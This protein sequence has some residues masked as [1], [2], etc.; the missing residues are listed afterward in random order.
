MWRSTQFLAER[1]AGML[2]STADSLSQLSLA[3]KCPI[4]T[5]PNEV[6]AKIFRIFISTSNEL[7]TKR[8]MLVCR[9]W[10]QVAGA[11][12]ELYGKIDLDKS[13]WSESRIL[14]QLKRSGATPLEV[15][16]PQLRSKTVI[17]PLLACADRLIALKVSGQPSNVLEL[18]RRMGNLR[19]PKLHELLLRSDG[20]DSRMG[21]RVAGGTWRQ[22]PPALLESGLPSLRKLTVLGI[23]GSFKSLAGLTSLSLAG[24]HASNPAAPLIALHDLL[25]MLAA[26]PGLE[27]LHIA[28]AT[29]LP[30]QDCD[31]ACVSLLHLAHLELC[32]RHLQF[33]LLLE[34]LLIPNTTI[35]DL[36]AIDANSAEE[37]RDAFTPLTTHLKKSGAPSAKML[38]LRIGGDDDFTITTHAKVRPRVMTTP[39]PWVDE[40][41]I[42]VSIAMDPSSVP[43]NEKFSVVKTLLEDVLWPQIASITHLDLRMAEFPQGMYFRLLLNMFLFNASPER[44]PLTLAMISDELCLEALLT[45]L[46]AE[47]GSRQMGQPFRHVPDIAR[48]AFSIPVVNPAEENHAAFITQ[49]QKILVLMCSLNAKKERVRKLIVTVHCIGCHA[50]RI[51]PQL[52][53]WNTQSFGAWERSWAVLGDVV[54]EFVWNKVNHSADDPSLVV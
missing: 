48:I 37:M 25:S 54:G 47:Y 28:G 13:G 26:N 36:F 10:N 4:D 1:A 51:R 16:I 11:A 31:Y 45:T 53:S 20:E 24:W 15:S 49:L 52:C 9:R 23:D 2:N 8:L 44:K 29:G 27:R 43:P 33:A 3:S 21:P 50:R 40:D 46:T 35:F 38:R 34:H 42:L 17:A 39:G 12:P 5:L 30:N 19:F 41:T 32:D 6:L 14:G 18:M 7:P 22:F